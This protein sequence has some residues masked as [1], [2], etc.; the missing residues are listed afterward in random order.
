ALAQLSHPN[1]VAVYDVGRV[2][3]GVFLAMELVHGETGDAW[4]KRRPGWRE[5]LAGFCDA[6]RGPAAAHPGGLVHRAFK[7]AH[8]IP[9]RDG[10]VR[11]LDFGLARTAQAGGDSG[12]HDS[13]ALA[14]LGDEAATWSGETRDAVREVTR[15]EPP[16]TPTTAPIE[17]AAGKES[18][19]GKE[20]RDG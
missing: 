6:G 11:V 10:R 19:D 1:V 2:D 20:P 7:P 4:I 14:S 12:E 17:P 15:D 13:A 9:G 3:G 8:L 5:V 16:K 18:R